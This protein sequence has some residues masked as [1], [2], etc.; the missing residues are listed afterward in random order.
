MAITAA[1]KARI[2]Q[3]AVQAK[4]EALIRKYSFMGNIHDPWLEANW[5]AAARAYLA[6]GNK[7]HLKNTPI[8]S[9]VDFALIP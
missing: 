5:D 8:F 2:K 4:R 3:A 1:K 6:D 9:K 7:E